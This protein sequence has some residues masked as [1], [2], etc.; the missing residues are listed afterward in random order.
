MQEPA[1]REA[2]AQTAD[3]PVGE[4]SLG[5]ADGVGVPL[6]RFVIV[7]RDEG[8]L[9]A[10]GEAHVF[11]LENA[12]DLVAEP[13][14]RFP[15]LLG[16]GLGDARMLRHPL[17]PHVENELGIGEADVAADDRGGVAVMRGRRER[18]VALA[19]QEARGRI[20]TDPARAGQI[21]FRPGVQVGEVVVGARRPVERDE[22]G[23]ELDEIAGHEAGGK[24]EM[25]QD[26]DEKPARVAA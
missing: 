16:E 12:V 19:G 25:A 15:R 11:G 20:E 7:D 3:Q 1:G 8:R 13:V 18:D 21:D 5:R 4:L 2:V 17:D 26:L 22:V 14:E 24:A 23:L 10:H 9:A 6:R